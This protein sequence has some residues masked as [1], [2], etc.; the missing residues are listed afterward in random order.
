MSKKKYYCPVC[1]YPELSFPPADY[2]ICPSCGTEFGYDDVSKSWDELR[3][4]WVKRGAVWFSDKTPKPEGWDAAKQ[5]YGRIS[6]S[7]VADDSHAEVEIQ[8]FVSSVQL[9]A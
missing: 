5:L 6:T 1:F 9:A 8:H 3:Q 4:E 2:N 7:S